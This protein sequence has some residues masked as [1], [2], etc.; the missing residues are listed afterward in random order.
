MAL[1]VSIPK[2]VAINKKMSVGKRSLLPLA[3]QA[4]PVGFMKPV[5]ISPYPG[6]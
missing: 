1:Y 2:G 3:K 5:S 6:S 4:P